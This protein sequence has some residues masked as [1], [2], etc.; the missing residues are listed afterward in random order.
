MVPAADPGYRAGGGHL[1]CVVAA[2]LESDEPL[3]Y[4]P[5]SVQVGP[6]QA[7]EP[8]TDSQLLP[9]P[10]LDRDGRTSPSG[11]HPERR[12]PRQ[13][14][15]LKLDGVTLVGLGRKVSGGTFPRLSC[16]RSVL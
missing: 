4:Q 2:H 5:P 8:P 12:L 14:H 15:S 7:L 6:T 11:G 9:Y 10:T 16:D 3:P 1:D 13:A